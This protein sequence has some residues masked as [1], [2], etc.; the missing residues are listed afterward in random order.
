LNL[1]QSNPVLSATV[2]ICTHNRADTLAACL[3]AISQL[4]YPEYNVLVVEN[5]AA[6]GRTRSLCD[7]QGVQY[8]H[9]PIIGLSRA[10][11]DGA[12]ACSTELVAYTDDDALPHED[13]LESLANE[14]Q[15]PSVMAVGG[16]VRSPDNGA[17][18]VRTPAGSL[19]RVRR[20]VDRTTDNWFAHANFGG[21]GMGNNM[22]FRRA[23]FELWPGFDERLG[24]GA[25]LNSAE[26]HFAFFQ[27][28]FLGHR[29]VYTPR[30]I[31]WHPKPDD[32]EE[33]LRIHYKNLSNAVAYAGILWSEFPETRGSL[34]KHLW[35]RSF[36]ERSRIRAYRD[37]AIRSW[38]KELHA[39]ADGIHLF[40][41]L[42]K[43][44]RSTALIQV[45]QTQKV[46]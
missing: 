32:P 34:L 2:V 31:V 23:A 26:E 4:R 43:P 21:V 12:R 3:H 35:S 36:G 29:C 1:A 22:C 8:L 37:S 46:S 38:R 40:W 14:F 44:T 33:L 17:K 25:P 19:G 16:V 20:V 39:I 45:T 15:E 9:S 24:R 41:K 10:R 18:R 28:V 5:G 7:E 11:N 30:A 13:W 6:D 27:L 42:P